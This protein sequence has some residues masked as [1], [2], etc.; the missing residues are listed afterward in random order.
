VNNPAGL[1]PTLFSAG[2]GCVN[3]CATPAIYCI[4]DAPDAEIMFY[5]YIGLKV[6]FYDFVFFLIRLLR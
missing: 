5:V 2:G 6:A 1:E 3:H 4:K